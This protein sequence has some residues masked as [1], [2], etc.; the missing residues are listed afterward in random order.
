MQTSP[1][2]TP[3]PFASTGHV[4]QAAPHGVKPE[5]HSNPQV[6]SEQLA[7]PLVGTGHG[8]QLVPH[9]AVEVFETQTPP[10]R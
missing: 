5:S 8:V 10:H 9:V 3:D 6:P 1:L 7:V 2:Q 4:V